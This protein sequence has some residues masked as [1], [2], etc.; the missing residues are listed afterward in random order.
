[1]KRILFVFALMLGLCVQP[2]W[3]AEVSAQAWAL[4]DG[5]SGRVLESVNG[6]EERLIASTTKL[7]TAYTAAQLNVDWDQV[8]TVSA[9]AAAT[10][11]SSLYLAP[12]E[13]IALGELLWGMLLVSGN[14]SATA[15]AEGCCGSVEAFVDE[16]NSCAQ[17]LGMTHSHFENPT[18]LDGETHY[19]TAEDLIKLAKA[20]LDDPFLAQV[21]GTKSATVAGRSLT[22]HNRLLSAYPGCIGLK[23]GYT[24]A[25]GRTLVSA[26]QRDG[27]TLICVTLS[28]PN[29]W[30]DHAALLD[31]GFSRYHLETLCQAG[32]IVTETALPQG[33]G[34]RTLC[35]EQAVTA[36]VG[37]GEEVTR[38]VTLTDLSGLI[39]NGSVGNITFEINGV[40]VGETPLVLRR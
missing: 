9:Q 4:G 35:T 17:E 7:M 13:E 26:A 16:M 25:A 2:A 40:P 37:E 32:E 18:G 33:L 3:A 28:D 5:D 12:G 23:T 10:E 34:G 31:E 39:P 29:D 6:S 30:T 22:N 20:V 1:M 14:D 8:V 19:S 38:T 15:L 21:V 27:V 36:L 24:Q 11:G